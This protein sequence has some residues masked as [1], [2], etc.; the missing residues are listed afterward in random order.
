MSESTIS[1]SEGGLRTNRAIALL[2]VCAVSV[3]AFTLAGVLLVVS[4]T[5]RIL[6]Q[7]EWLRHT[8][9]VLDELTQDAARLERIGFQM[10]LFQATR[11]DSSFRSVLTNTVALQTGA[12]RLQQLVQDNPTQSLHNRDLLAAVEELSRAID[13]AQQTG[14]VPETRLRD[15]R[16]LLNAMQ[17]EENAL[18][19]QRRS[20]TQNSIWRPTIWGSADLVFSMLVWL[21]LFWILIRDAVR[22]RQFEERLSRANGSLATTV[23]ALGARVSEAM[24][25]KHARDELQLCVTAQE[26]YACTARHMAQL[27]PGSSGAVLIINNSRSMLIMSSTWNEPAGLLDGFES[28][29]CCGLRTGRAR[30]RK[31]GESEI[32]CAHFIG[33]PPENYLCIPLAA[34]GE[35]LGFVYLMLPDKAVSELAA[36]RLP[37]VAEMVELAAMTIAGLNLRS[38]LENQSIRDGL[39]NLFNRHFMEIALEREVQRATRSR[40]PLAVLMLDVDH[41]KSFN[42]LFGHEAGDLVLRALAGCLQS[43]V[44]VEDIVCRYGGEEFVILLPEI[45]PEMAWDAAERLRQRVA[46]M[47]VEFRGEPLRQISI[48]V[49]LC[50]YPDGANDAVELLRKADRALYQ[51]KHAGRNQVQVAEA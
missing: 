43:S 17:A 9:V 8:H 41:F 25:L 33:T 29:A 31:P 49:G 22:R 37:L 18:L 30:W 48:S 11:Q 20:E 5:R 28:D 27:I 14:A 10:Q 21:V 16:R 4:S 6:S 13:A 1:S 32:H 39:T 45:T 23:E 51:A 46:A 15:V 12:L 40:A 38:K 36:Q 42:D 50:T 44:R 2:I 19:G 3:L 34:L 26:A 24:L 47:A 7:N 35:T